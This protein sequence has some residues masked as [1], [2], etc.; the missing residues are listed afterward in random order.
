VL[1]L[2]LLIR[3]PGF[4]FPLLYDVPVALLAVAF[5]VRGG[6]IGGAIGMVFFTISDVTATIHSNAVGCASRALTFLLLGLFVGLLSD[7]LRH[8]Q[9]AQQ[10]AE[11]N[12][13]HAVEINDNVVQRLVV[14]KYS[15]DQGNEAQG[16]QKLADGLREAQHFVT[17]LLGDGG[18]KAGALRRKEAAQTDQPAEPPNGPTP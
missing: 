14:A 7:Y 15:L 16:R 12:R 17:S 8:A 9:A 6:L 10:R 5:G 2:R 13:A 4:G 11:M 1:G 3:T 18:V